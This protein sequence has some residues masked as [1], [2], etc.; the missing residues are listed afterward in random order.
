MT[1]TTA[2]PPPGA[3]PGLA[4]RRLATTWFRGR[5]FQAGPQLELFLVCAAVGVIFNRSF[6]ILTGYPQIGNATLHISHAIWGALAMMAAL[7][8]YLTFLS[9]TL[10][11]FIAVL[12]GFGFGWFVDELG[13]FI[14]RD[15][16]YLFRP[17]LAVIYCVFIGM[18]FWFR[19]LAGRPADADDAVLN[20]LSALQAARLGSLTAA[21]RDLALRRLVDLDD[22]APLTGEVH[23]LLAATPASPPLAELRIRR[24]GTTLRGRY[25]AWTERP[26][27]VPLVSVIFGLI[28]LA[29]VASVFADAFTRGGATFST[30]VGAA[31]AALFAGLVLTGGVLL[32][33]NR[34]RAFRWFNRAVLV[35]ILVIQVF[36]FDRQ[37]FGAVLGLLV[38]LAVWG[39]LRSAM[40]IEA[41]RAPD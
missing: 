9:P 14:S 29:V 28:T 35:W 2:A 22:G 18:F 12:G 15:T 3:L 23:A 34:A 40:A 11:G 4:G 7:T 19:Y 6:L 41:R 25:E 8:L 32:P 10:R 5:S 31:A 39:L 27:F 24:W 17:A 21:D 26:S 33:R 38:A 20:A 37:Q 36:R 1:E 30:W 16:D 13:K